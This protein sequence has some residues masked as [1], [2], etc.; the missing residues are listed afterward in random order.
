M[1]ALG[2][3]GQLLILMVECSGACLW[4]TVKQHHVT[5]PRSA[6]NNLQDAVRDLGR[7]ECDIGDQFQ[8]IPTTQSA[9]SSA[10]HAIISG[11]MHYTCRYSTVSEIAVKSRDQLKGSAATVKSNHACLS[12]PVPLPCSVSSSI[13]LLVGPPLVNGDL[14]QPPLNSRSLRVACMMSTE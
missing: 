13:N 11:R 9:A 7:G 4:G 1:P 3:S 6:L 2:P 12:P 14:E 5:T 10:V 8:H